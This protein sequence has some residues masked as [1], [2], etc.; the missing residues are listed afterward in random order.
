MAALLLSASAAWAGDK[1][2]TGA[3]STT[4]SAGT[5]WSPAGVPVAGD[6]AIINSVANNPIVTANTTIDQL[7]VNSGATV[8]INNG[9]TLTVVGSGNPIIDGTGTVL[10]L[11]TGL[12]TVTG[13]NNNGMLF[14]D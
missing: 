7:V 1:T 5:N 13:A 9:I 2:W 4:W 8:T 10:T 11:G 12:L 14:N 6:R 3:T